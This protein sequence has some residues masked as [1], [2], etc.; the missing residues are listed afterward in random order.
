MNGQTKRGPSTQGML[1]GHRKERALPHPTTRMTLRNTTLAGGSQTQS[2][3]VSEPIF[4]K[5][6]QE[7][8]PQRLKVDQW[9][10]GA[11]GGGGMERRLVGTGFLRRVMNT[12]WN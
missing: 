11:G 12:F 6:P 7:A 3:T 1:S 2:H 8:N 10:L 4:M 9:S 5:R